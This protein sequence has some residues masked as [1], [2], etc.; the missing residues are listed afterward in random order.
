MGGT[1]FSHVLQGLLEKI[2][3]IDDGLHYGYDSYCMIYCFPGNNI[4][5]ERLWDG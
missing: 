5:E 4:K 2:N 3:A 1:V